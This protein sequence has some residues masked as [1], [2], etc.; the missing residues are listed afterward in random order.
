MSR[1][2]GKWW[3]IAYSSAPIQIA[4]LKD[5]PH[6]LNIQTKWEGDTAGGCI[7]HPTFPKNPKYL[8]SFPPKITKTYIVVSQDKNLADV[9]KFNIT[10]YKYYI[11][12]YLY[13]SD[14]TVPIEVAP[15][16]KTQ[17]FKN[18]REG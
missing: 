13:D 4:P 2:N 9:E 3:I 18:T 11:G 5:W 16:F 15:V 10:S 17:K 12:F 7:E 14:I 8:L 6:S 1:L